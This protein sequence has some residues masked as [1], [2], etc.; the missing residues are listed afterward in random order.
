MVLIDFYYYY[1][2]VVHPSRPVRYSCDRFLLNDSERL[3]LV[4]GH[5][6][7]CCMF[8]YCDKNFNVS[9]NRSRYDQNVFLHVLVLDQIH[10][11]V[12][13]LDLLSFI[14]AAAAG[15]AAG[16]VD[17]QVEVDKTGEGVVVYNL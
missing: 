5:D 12:H 9:N 7:Y 11:H 3:L 16:T 13:V 2:Y 10:D 6:K 17:W 1:Q 15:I 8:H 14:R 4:D